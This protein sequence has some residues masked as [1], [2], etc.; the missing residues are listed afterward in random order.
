LI[1]IYDPRKFV[2][3]VTVVQLSGLTTH[4]SVHTHTHIFTETLTHREKE[5]DRER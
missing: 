2:S 4:M 1:E 3:D 5:R